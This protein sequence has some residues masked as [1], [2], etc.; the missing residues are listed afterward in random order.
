M[1]NQRPDSL[2]NR[3]AFRT[4]PRHRNRI[5]WLSAALTLFVGACAEP[6][7]NV[8][9][10]VPANRFV[11]LAVTDLR[12]PKGSP[13]FEAFKRTQDLLDALWAESTWTVLAPQD[14]RVLHPQGLDHPGPLTATDLVV[15]AEALQLDHQLF[16]LLSYGVSV[17]ESAGQA[18]VSKG[19]DAGVGYHG[20][21][22][23]V[24][25]LV[26]RDMAGK[27][28][29]E[30]EITRAVDP[31]ADHPDYDARP[32]LGEAVHDL[33]RQLIAACE[34]CVTAGARPAI[35]LR[36]SPSL[37][38]EATDEAGRTLRQ[39]LET[40]GPLEH[41]QL[42]WTN[43]QYLDPGLELKAAKHH[44]ET[45][46]VACV[47]ADVKAPFLAG[48]CITTLDGVRL[49]SRHAVARRLATGPC[50]VEVVGADGATRTVQLD[51]AL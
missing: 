11:A 16:G 15:R 27:R 48:D 32:E 45:P 47:T 17:R 4:Y 9:I 40:A 44:L 12:M 37:I 24:V 46:S 8:K 31:F 36:P 39:H 43:M 2:E 49:P 28:V 23:V 34:G 14:F 1:R 41:D 33:T 35:D 51:G 42:L 19:D 13:D 21:S 18:H 50:T 29:A 26:M 6:S 22:D 38:L 5:A 3:C 20:S 10:S 25:A 30:M 7:A